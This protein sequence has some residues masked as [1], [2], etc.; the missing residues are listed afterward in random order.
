[1]ERGDQRLDRPSLSGH[2]DTSLEA[3]LEDG[4]VVV[5]WRKNAPPREP[6][7]YNLTT[8][9]I[10]LNEQTPDTE[11]AAPTDCRRRPDQHCLEL[12]EYDTVRLEKGGVLLAGM[13]WEAE[14][15]V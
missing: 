5:L 8:F 7:R 6:T 10:Q 11:R 13:P 15:R 14:G 9:A 3:E 2:W 12:G 1:M 4:R